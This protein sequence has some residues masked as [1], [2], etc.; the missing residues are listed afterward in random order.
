MEFAVAV[1]SF[2]CMAGSATL[3][4]LAF[5][6]NPEYMVGS[7]SLS[8]LGISA[9]AW[10]FNTATVL[11]G[12]STVNFT[13]FVLRDRVDAAERLDRSTLYF[14]LLGGTT[15]V[16]LGFVPAAHFWPHMTLA[17]LFFLSAAAAFLHFAAY[18]HRCRRF[19]ALYAALACFTSGLNVALVLTVALMLS[20][21]GVPAPEG[22]MNGNFAAVWLE[23]IAVFAIVLTLIAV[24]LRHLLTDWPNAYE[25]L[26]AFFPFHGNNRISVL[27]VP[28]ALGPGHRFH[29]RKIA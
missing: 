28:V 9:V 6:L 23:S 13:W 29:S 24:Q 16:F 11:A 22:I 25:A 10:P 17:S 12:V 2:A 8:R 18:L 19:G 27:K 20:R 1:A 15:A 3:Y 7:H 5:L 4:A 26:R 14:L 21:E